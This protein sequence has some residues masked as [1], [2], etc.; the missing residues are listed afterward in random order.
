MRLAQ[1]RY[2]RSI[3]VY[4]IVAALLAAGTWMVVARL[5]GAASAEAARYGSVRD[6]AVVLRPVETGQVVTTADIGRRRIPAAFVPEA[7]IVDDPVGMVALAPLASG[8]VFLAARLA[9]IG[10]RG[11]A[12]LVP[13]GHRA[14]A[15]PAGP[16]TP[17]VRVGDAVDVYV[18][19]AE[20]EATRDDGA[21][22][23]AVALGT[24]VVAVDRA[25]ETVTISVPIEDVPRVAF[26]IAA[27][28][29]TLA[30]AGA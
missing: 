2:Q 5:V 22:T 25:A 4:W 17:P 7:D 3:L 15:V 9:P 26:A 10:L 21:P 1:L 13:A 30:L 27:A 23:F 24:R 28:T 18:T 14:L 19:L 16:G 6:V 8:E 29:V 20:D 11:V 12:A